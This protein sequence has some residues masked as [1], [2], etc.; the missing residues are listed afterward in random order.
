[1]NA[2]FPAQTAYNPPPFYSTTDERYGQLMDNIRWQPSPLFRQLTDSLFQH[3]DETCEIPSLRKSAEGIPYTVYSDSDGCHHPVLDRNGFYSKCVLDIKCNPAA[4][5]AA[6][7]QIIQAYQ[8][9]DPRT[10]NYFSIPLPRSVFPLTFNHDPVH[11]KAR[12]TRDRAWKQFLDGWVFEHSPS[13]TN[14]SRLVTVSGAINCDKCRNVIM[15]TRYKCN[16]CFD[17]D[18]CDSC[19][20]SASISPPG[21]VTSPVTSPTQQHHERSHPLQR[22]YIPY[23]SRICDSCGKQDFDMTNR[24]L[25]CPEYDEC[26]RCVSQKSSDSAMPS[27]T[28][29]PSATH[30]YWH[31]FTKTYVAAGS[32]VCDICKRQNQLIKNHCQF[33]ADYDECEDCR[34]SRIPQASLGMGDIP[35]LTAPINPMQT[36]ESSRH[37]HYEEKSGQQAPHRSQ[38][39]ETRA[40]LI[41]SI[42]HS[43]FN[44]ALLV[45]SRGFRQISAPLN[46]RRPTISTYP[47]E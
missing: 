36:P 10:G 42:T 45:R 41:A 4:Q 8:L 19:F 24:C 13:H 47:K 17:F 5:H 15:G 26:D 3:L 32:F 28:T 38:S 1:M 43:T 34:R 9:R 11:V 40:A 7:A 44:T 2:M 12:D 20:Y 14:F 46:P 21:I 25:V 18:E 16:T 29:G 30:Q 33:C 39:A 27:P 23:A 37:L 22:A 31:S 35:P 6:W